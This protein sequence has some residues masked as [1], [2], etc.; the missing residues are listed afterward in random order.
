VIATLVDEGDGVTYEPVPDVFA[1]VRPAC[2][3][4]PWRG[5][6]TTAATYKWRMW[7]AMDVHQH[8]CTADKEKPS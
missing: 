1:A 5:R 2:P 8:T 6:P 7:I 4:C 3:R